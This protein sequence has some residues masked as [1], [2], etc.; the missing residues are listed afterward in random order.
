VGDQLLG[1]PKYSGGVQASYDLFRRTLLNAGITH[2]GSWTNPDYLALYG[3]FFGGQEYRGSNR[4]YW[5]RYPSVTKLNA[6]LQQSIDE[7]L[8][9]LLAVDNLTNNRRFEEIN[10]AVTPGRRT[11][12]GV[13]LNY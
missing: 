5:I 7:H 9:L 1:I 6:G 8:S 11:T 13:R 10:L 3:F 2:I 12:V 4:A